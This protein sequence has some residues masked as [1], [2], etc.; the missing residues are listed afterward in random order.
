MAYRKWVVGE[1]CGVCGKA[2][3]PDP[4]LLDGGM[5]ACSE[6][7][8]WVCSRACF[9]KTLPYSFAEEDLIRKLTGSGMLLRQ[10]NSDRV[11][12]A[13]DVIRKSVRNSFLIRRDLTH[14]LYSTDKDVLIAAIEVL[15]PHADENTKSILASIA[16]NEMYISEVREA[17]RGI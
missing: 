6:A 4:E 2:G 14:L 11:I 5:L 3:N 16:N 17:A 9:E 10:S 15:K 12:N 7:I 8:R 1:C 13:L